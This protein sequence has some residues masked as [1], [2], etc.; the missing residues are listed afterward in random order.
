MNCWLSR[1]MMGVG[2]LAL[3]GHAL[4]DDS[5][6]VGSSEQSSENPK[7]MGAA[8][9]ARAEVAFIDRV[10]AAP[11]PPAGAEEHR[12]GDDQGAAANS[13]EQQQTTSLFAGVRV[14][15]ALPSGSLER[16]VS[17]PDY[18]NS[19]AGL[20]A[21]LGLRLLRNF[22]IQATFEYYKLSPG[23]ELDELASGLS[24]TDQV[25]MTSTASGST[26]GLSFLAGTQPGKIG[27]YGELG[28]AYQGY[29]WKRNV[30]SLDESFGSCSESTDYAGPAGRLG[31][32]FV[33][34]VLANLQLTAVANY[35]AG[36][37][38]KRDYSTGCGFHPVNAGQQFELPLHKG[39]HQQL[40]L[41]LGADFTLGL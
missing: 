25:Q 20:D 33:Y 24:S 14:G 23:S 3:A 29:G 41:G 17:M 2:V 21:H 35:T 8:G 31:G 6:A 27:G 10:G 4:A 19:G 28:V 37:F 39:W 7:S 38:T 34:P 16:D 32:G 30:V 22:G 40:F 15:A 18:I 13:P 36:V 11:L 5:S 1:L 26:L 9:D 12:P